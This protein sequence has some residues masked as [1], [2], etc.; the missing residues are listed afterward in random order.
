MIAGVNES[1]PD[2]G[3]GPQ[4]QT[5]TIQQ[6]TKVQE[7]VIGAKNYGNNAGNIAKN[8]TIILNCRGRCEWNTDTTTNQRKNRIII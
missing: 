6:S 2:R 4:K 3:A 1:P 7:G 5:I 8:K